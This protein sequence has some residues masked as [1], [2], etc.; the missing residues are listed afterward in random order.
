MALVKYGFYPKLAAHFRSV[1]VRFGTRLCLCWVLRKLGLFSKITNLSRLATRYGTRTFNFWSYNKT[2]LVANGNYSEAR[3][4]YFVKDCIYTEAAKNTFFTDHLRTTSPGFILCNIQEIKVTSSSNIKFQF[5]LVSQRA[6]QTPTPKYR[7]SC[8]EVSLTTCSKLTGEHPC[9]SVIIIK[10][11]SNFI[12]ITLR[13]WCSPVYLLHIFR[14]PFLKNTSG[15]LFLNIC[16]R[17]CLNC[18]QHKL[19]ARSWIYLWPWGACSRKITT[20]T[21]FLWWRENLWN[22]FMIEIIPRQR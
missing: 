6:T 21:N 20:A 3:A 5:W 12:E 4:R 8:L 19:K 18:W 7:S 16:D 17:K 15:E 22:I 9:R 10:L 2:L 13:H 1:F 11:Q 14:T